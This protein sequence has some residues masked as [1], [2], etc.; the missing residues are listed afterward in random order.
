MEKY[1]PRV[2]VPHGEISNAEHKRARIELDMEDIVADPGLRKPIEDFP[3]DIRDEAKRAYLTMGPCQ[4][5]GHNF[6]QKLQSAQM[7]SFINTWYKIFDW[8]E[9]SVEKDDIIL[10]TF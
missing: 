3:P 7:R 1:Y 9:Y 4:L 2:L 8:L 10:K 5:M 6:P